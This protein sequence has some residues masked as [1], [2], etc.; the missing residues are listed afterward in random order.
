MWQNEV[1]MN[2][3]QLPR[4]LFC[5]TLALVACLFAARAAAEIVAL[6][7]ERRGRDFTMEFDARFAP[8]APRSLVLRLGSADRPGVPPD[9]LSFSK[10]SIDFA[11]N[12]TRTLDFIGSGY[13]GTPFM[14]QRRF[15]LPFEVPD[16]EW[17]HVRVVSDGGFV[18]FFVQFGDKLQRTLTNVLR[19]G[20]SLAGYEFVLP[21]GVE[22]ANVKVGPFDEGDVPPPRA[23][24]SVCRTPRTVDIPLTDGQ[25]SFA[26]IPGGYPVE[27]LLGFDDGTTNRLSAKFASFCESFTHYLYN[28]ERRDKAGVEEFERGGFGGNVRI[29]DYGMAFSSGDA[30][31]PIYTYPKLGSRYG[32]VQIIHMMTNLTAFGEQASDHAF[33]CSL[34]RRR[35]RNLLYVDG[36]YAA[37]IGSTNPVSALTLSLPIGG[38]WRVDAPPP[39][40]GAD[41]RVVKIPDFA[42][43][44]TAV[45]RVNLGSF[46]LEC[47]GYLSRGA[48]E[49]QA[50]SFLRRVPVGTYLR[51]KVRCRLAGDTNANT[52]VTARLTNF[53]SPNTAGRSPESVTQQ[54]VELPRGL[55]GETNVVFQFDAGKIQDVIWQRGFDYLDFE[56]LGDS[57]SRHGY[58]DYEFLMPVG[59]SDV[60]VLGAELE[61]AP[62][63]MCVRSGNAPHDPMFWPHE[64]ASVTAEVA[65]L[66]A[67]RYRVAWE[68]ADIDGKVRE[69]GAEDFDLAAGANETR[70]IVFK[71]R[72]PGWYG[73]AV[74]LE[75]AQG[76]TILR[77][78]TSYVSLAEDTRK[79]GYESPFFLWTGLGV[80]S[81]DRAAFERAMDH[82][83]RL[84]VRKGQMGTFS[85]ADGAPWGVTLSPLP[86]SGGFSSKP[87]E[88]ERIADY[89][90]R[91]RDF[92]AR[93]PHATAATIFHESGN[94]R[95]R[96]QPPDP[97]QD[98][99]EIRKATE[100]CRTWRRL[101]PQVKLVLGNGSLDKVAQILRNKFPR[102]LID[103]MGEEATGAVRPPEEAVGEV[104]QEY[105]DVADQYGY[106]DLPVTPCYEWKS[107]PAR[108][109][110][111]RRLLAAYLVRDAL[112]ALAWGA[113]HVTLE[114][115]YESDSSYFMSSWGAGSFSHRPYG[116]PYPSAAALATLTRALDQATYARVVPTGSETVYAVEYR[117]AAGGFVTALWTTRGTVKAEVAAAGR[118]VVRTGTYGEETPLRLSLAKRAA[119]EVC[120][121]PIY[122][123]TEEPL[124]EVAVVPGDR[125]F[126]FDRYPGI[127]KT[128]TVAPLDSLADVELDTNAYPRVIA[129]KG[130]FTLREADDPVRGKCLELER[131]ASNKGNAFGGV[132]L[133]EPVVLDGKADTIGLWVKGNSSMGRVYFDIRD[134]RGRRFYSTSQY[135]CYDWCGKMLLNYDGWR[136]ISFPLTEASPVRIQTHV[137]DLGNWY[138]VGLSS[139]WSPPVPPVSLLGIGFAWGDTAVHVNERHP[140]GSNVVRFAAFGVY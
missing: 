68:V 46:A 14:E 104:F 98:A 53:F 95:P 26:F 123:T 54:T 17:R 99:E 86:F 79:A 13:T 83:H 140:V 90:A 22:V 101:A 85:E 111:S 29:P 100:L 67:G 137:P 77:H 94:C 125:D 103:A 35:G 70:R 120:E 20:F 60:V 58:F 114:G 45:C 78:D 33:R 62:A 102:D 3:R 80:H 5:A 72:T 118:T 119:I 97:A 64:E 66:L 55:K 71:T 127:E 69:S 131:D 87:T 96:N 135:H 138:M 61:L 38:C 82:L 109:F 16:G 56:V 32:A 139:E 128:R 12:W 52:K 134:A 121:E 92:M 6:P 89:E 10:T 49:R 88:A 9:K 28:V 106:N 91:I 116:Y 81:K 93:F 34:V 42:P 2:T 124:K 40:E 136:F 37:T 57:I 132:R 129:A 23:G 110:D 108:N 41:P 31:F 8:G 130:V 105:R 39:A 50:E 84:G 75:D 19:K 51:A 63:G 117:R 15:L 27:V 4:P 25:A 24:Y 76:R 126:R 113:E 18:T 73:V 48:F 11:G 112:I 21:E 43:F 65:A 74:R 47:N 122:L 44:A 36:N 30:S 59:T 7:E 133:R 115:G 1:T 107:R